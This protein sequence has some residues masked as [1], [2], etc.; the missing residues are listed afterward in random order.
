MT[1]LRKKMEAD[2]RL[3][4]LAPNTRYQYLLCVGVF[5]KYHG[6][7]PAKLGTEEVRA[8]LLHLRDKRRAPATLGVYWAALRFV[9]A[10]TLARPAVMND[11]PR[12]RVP[13]RDSMPALTVAEVRALL[14]ATTRPFDRSLLSLMYA[15]G[16]R[17]SEACALQ[18]GDI[19]TRAGLIHIRH[20]KGGKARSVRLSPG[21]LSML[22][23]HWRQHRLPG[24][25]LFAAQRMLRP[26]VVDWRAPWQHAPVS[27]C[28]VSKRFYAIRRRAGLRRRVT[29]HDLRRAYATHLLEAGVD[30]RTIQ[31]LLGHARPETTA[32]YTA[33][34]AEMIKR[35]PC[36]L[37]S[38]G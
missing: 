4:G 25:W 38:L 19:D 36:L 34:S 1:A 30:L 6:R 23:A 29:L 8:F 22:R 10:V 13:R 9:Y 2:L 5:A 16:L 35:T 37:E 17:S 14:K 24:P 7:S 28:A 27:Y 32:Q 33:V 20:G 26:G 11:V 15:C 12:P 31:V 18:A 21:V 3:R